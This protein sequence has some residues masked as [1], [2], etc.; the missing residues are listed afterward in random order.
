MLIKAIQCVFAA[1][2]FAILIDVFIREENSI[3]VKWII[4]ISTG[5]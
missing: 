4:R 3:F 5:G 2:P 1:I